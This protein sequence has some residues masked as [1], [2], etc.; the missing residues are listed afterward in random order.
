[1]SYLIRSS[2]K[3]AIAEGRIIIDPYEDSLVSVNS[4]DVRLGDHLKVYKHKTLD[5]KGEN[6]T[7]TIKIPKTGFWMLPQHF[8]LGITLER[9][10]TDYFIPTLDGKSTT[11]RLNVGIHVTAGRGDIGWDG[12]FTLEMYVVAHDIKIYPGMLIG[13][14]FFETPDKQPLPE[15]L[16]SGK[17]QGSSVIVEG[18]AYK[19][20]KKSERVNNEKGN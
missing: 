3:Q 5:M 17:Y 13:Q 8:Y 19:D 2:I 16:Y 18:L 20:F 1:M 12:N 7:K 14:V 10:A 9:I 15:D 4:V 6:P 11:A